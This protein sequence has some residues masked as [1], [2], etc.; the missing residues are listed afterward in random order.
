MRE[1]SAVIVGLGC[2]ETGFD[3]G[4]VAVEEGGEVC[5]RATTGRTTSSVRARLAG[6]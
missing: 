1:S 6:R 2:G 5:R 4:E 3:W